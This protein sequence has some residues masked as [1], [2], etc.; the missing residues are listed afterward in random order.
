M[1][2]DGR[3]ATT[4]AGFRIHSIALKVLVRDLGPGTADDWLQQAAV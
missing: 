4:P 2:F 3:P 1:A